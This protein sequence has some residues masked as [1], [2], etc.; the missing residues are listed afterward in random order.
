MLATA[1]GL[2][3]A[4]RN[5]EARRV[6]FTAARRVRMFVS[7]NQSGG[8]NCG[9]KNKEAATEMIH[10]KLS[11][12]CRTELFSAKEASD[13]IL[14]M[15]PCVKRSKCGQAECFHHL[16]AFTLVEVLVVLGVIA[17]LIALAVPGL[18]RTRQAARDLSDLSKIRQLGALVTL[19]AGDY[20]DVPPVIF[21]PVFVSRQLNI[22]ELKIGYRGDTLSG[23]WFSNAGMFHLA[24]DPVAPTTLVRAT[25]AP[26]RM[27]KAHLTSGTT[28]LV[29]DFKLADVFYADP[30]FW[31]RDRQ[32]G[33]VQWGA[34]TLSSV[35]FP[36]AK[37][38]LWQTIVYTIPGHP[39]GVQGCCS[40]GVQ[41][42]ILWADQSASPQN[43]AELLPGVPNSWGYGATGPVLNDAK[44]PPV[45]QTEFGVLGRDR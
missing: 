18:V 22:P 44:G 37:G 10:M 4:A 24:F 14:A 38:M 13:S 40:T 34:Q 25:G 23:S 6:F 28:A 11:F 19:Y 12:N 42:A 39:E 21:P 33:P 45:Y 32:I 2:L 15:R 27:Y 5:V 36:S 30:E 17:V 8:K 7:E 31:T 1:A 20:R 41:T 26:K 3:V 43:M 16:R 29:S 35:A 9:G